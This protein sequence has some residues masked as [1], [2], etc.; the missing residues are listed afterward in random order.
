MH[1]SAAINAKVAHVANYLIGVF[2][3]PAGQ[4]ELAGVKVLLEEMMAADVA[5]ASILVVKIFFRV[6]TRA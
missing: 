1:F 4:F 3:V 6:R 2:H 5:F